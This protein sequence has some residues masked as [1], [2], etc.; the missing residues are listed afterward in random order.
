[1]NEENLT[2]ICMDAM[3]KM[4]DE[5]LCWIIRHGTKWLHDRL[6]YLKKDIKLKKEIEEAEKV[7]A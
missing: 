1:M 5:E 2:I 7:M 6:Y 4:T 3:R